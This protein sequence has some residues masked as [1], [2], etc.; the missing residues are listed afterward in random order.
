[1]YTASLLYP[2][3]IQDALFLGLEGAPTP[4]SG[5]AALKGLWKYLVLDL[6]KNREGEAPRQWVVR[7]YPARG[8]FELVRAVDAGELEGLTPTGNGRKGGRA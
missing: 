8:A 5:R 2:L 6:V 7:W 3:G 4:G 1:A